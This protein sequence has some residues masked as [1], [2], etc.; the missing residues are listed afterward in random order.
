HSS[1]NGLVERE[2]GD[3]SDGDSRIAEGAFDGCRSSLFE[4]SCCTTL[5]IA[6]ASQH[7]GFSSGYAR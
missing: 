4:L 6:V 1:G 7:R 5:I 3:F 2:S